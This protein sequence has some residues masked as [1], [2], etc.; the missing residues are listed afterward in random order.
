MKSLVTGGAG[1]IG[2]HV[3]DLLIKEGHEVIVIDNLSTG[4]KKNLNEKA[5]FYQIDLSNYN[6]VR[7]IFEREKPDY[8]FH[9]AAQIDVRKS[10]EDPIFD[11]QQNILNAINLLELSSKNKVKHF[12]FSS[13]GGA[14]YGD[15]ELPTKEETIEKPISPYGVA[16]LTIEK[17]LYYFNVVHG[18]HYTILRYSNVYGPRQNNKGEAGV[19]A[20]FY[21]KMLNNENPTIFGGPQTRDFVFVEDVAKANL[22]ALKDNKNDFYNV[23]TGTEISI[24]E[25]FNK[26]NLIFDNKFSPTMKE[27]KKGEQ[28]TSCLSI[29]KI[30]KIL[31]W[32]PSI[33]LDEGLKK[34]LDW[35]KT[36]V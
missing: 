20:V 4:S 28:L 1:F 21:N 27:S 9:L 16:K 22:L 11:A 26:I 32:T 6:L 25:L 34:T 5:K 7:Q 8:V 36:Q 14:I 15:S 10:V 17:Y 12:I 30:N 33:S 18:L 29:E 35:Y 13:S 31:G 2:S 23:A 19:V 3:V 24:I